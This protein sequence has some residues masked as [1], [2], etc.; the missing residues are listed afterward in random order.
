MSSTLASLVV[1]LVGD[2]AG[3]KQVTPAPAPAGDNLTAQ[4]AKAAR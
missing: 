2:T 3:M 4:P 1:K